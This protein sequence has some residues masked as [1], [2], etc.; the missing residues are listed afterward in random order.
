MGTNRSAGQTTFKIQAFPNNFEGA[1]ERQGQLVKLLNSKVCPCVKNGKAPFDCDICSGKGYILS[2]QKEYEIIDENSPHNICGLEDEI[3]PHWIPIKKVVS[4]ERILHSIQGG[5]TKYTISSFTD[6]K[7]V[8]ATGQDFPKRYETLRVNYSYE[9][10]NTVVAE[11]SLADG[12]YVVKTTGTEVEI[13]GASNRY[14]VHGDIY[15]IS[16]VYNV[17]QDITYTVSKFGK[18]FIFLDSEGGAKP[19]PLSTDI[20]E[21]DY[22]WT[23]PFQAYC[24]WVDPKNSLQV[25][26]PDVQTGD[27]ECTPPGGFNIKK[28]S[29]FVL[30]TSLVDKSSAMKRGVDDHEVFP[31]F[32]VLDVTENILDEDGAEY[33]SGTDFEVQEYNHLAWLSGGSSPAVGKKYTVCY[34]YHPAYRVYKGETERLAAENKRFPQKVLLRK[35]DKL[36]LKS[37]EIL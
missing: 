33:V 13:D 26:G 11:A 15:S 12:T 3:Y 34:R 23:P 28:G 22:K 32:H 27:I 37:L 17:T 8:L 19:A 9:L 36:D 14:E 10:Q 7:I 20:L 24:N 1:V 6:E 16:R 4:V 2:F 25:W 30:Y 18:R 21:V 5:N 35:F 29:I 31:V